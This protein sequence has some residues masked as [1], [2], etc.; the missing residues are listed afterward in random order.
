MAGRARTV[1][2]F[3][4][5][6]D[7]QGLQAGQSAKLLVGRTEV[8]HI[9]RVDDQI[10]TR[11]DIDCPVFVAEV[12]LDTLPGGKVAK[13]MPLPE[14]PAVER[15]LVFLFDRKAGSDEI[16]QAAAKAAGKLMADVRLFDRYDGKG[17][18]EGKVSLGLRF[19]LQDATRT[20][21]QQDSDAAVAAV[22]AAMEQKFGAALRG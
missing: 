9:G 13:F 1:A 22:V 2:R 17:V 16:L 4:A 21:T 3:I 11:L 19:M 8:G 15:D 5:D 12:S 7:I 6:D 20:L 10:V 14:F 18:P